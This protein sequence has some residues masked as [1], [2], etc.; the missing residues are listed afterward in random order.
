MPREACECKTENEFCRERCF[1][2]RARMMPDYDD[3]SR[4]ELV[5]CRE[6][7]PMTR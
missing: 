1:M 7:C 3:E 6:F 4:L 2:R 5:V